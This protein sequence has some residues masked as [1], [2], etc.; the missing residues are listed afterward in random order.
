MVPA[1]LALALG[2]AVL[3][4]YLSQRHAAG[5]VEDNLLR[6]EQIH[7]DFSAQGDHREPLQ[8]GGHGPLVLFFHETAA[9]GGSVE[10]YLGFLGEPYRIWAPDFEEPAHVAEARGLGIFCVPALVEQARGFLRKAR[11]LAGDDPL[12]VVG[13]SRGASLAVLALQAEPETSVAG[14]VLESFF[15]PRDV[16][17]AKVQRFAPIYLGRGPAKLLPEAWL[18]FCAGLG[19]ARVER[20]LGVN[21]LETDAA[22]IELPRRVLFVHGGRDPAAPVTAVRRYVESRRARHRETGLEVFAKARHNGSSQKEP[23]RYREVVGNFLAEVAGVA[24]STTSAVEP[25]G[26][27]AEV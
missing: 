3:V 18:R 16:L 14:V 27:G 15:S 19:L 9:D 6:M 20:R 5:I 11:E 17:T 8:P 10:K 4:L 1:A 13:V 2:G 7:L 12:I 23:E 24:Q 22:A 25:A 21:F 26:G